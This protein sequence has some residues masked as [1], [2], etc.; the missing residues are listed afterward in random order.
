MVRWYI[1]TVKVN[2]RNSFLL[3]VNSIDFYLQIICEFAL[4]LFASLHI[5]SSSSYQW[6]NA[7]E[8]WSNVVCSMKDIK[9]MNFHGIL[10]SSISKRNAIFLEQYF[11][12]FIYDVTRK[13]ETTILSRIY[14]PP[15][16]ENLFVNNNDIAYR[17]VKRPSIW[18]IISGDALPSRVMPSNNVA[19]K[20]RKIR[21]DKTFDGTWNMHIILIRDV[22]FF[23]QISKD[24][25][26][27]KWNSHDRFIVLFARF[28]E[29]HRLSN[30][31]NSRIDDILKTLWFKHKV[32]KVF[33]SEVI[34]INDTIRI[35]RTVRTYNPFTK[36]NNS[37]L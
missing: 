11:Q 28:P 20:I 23:D 4:L 35:D 29:E 33:V 31:L 21:S 27:F 26:T 10:E 18:K 9:T 1:F 16:S 24:G 3:L 37:G 13:C 7:I 32:H 36:V 15:D 12:A 8:F 34:L 17:V 25:T 2:W 5:A 30:K 14:T 6:Y 19:R 22:H